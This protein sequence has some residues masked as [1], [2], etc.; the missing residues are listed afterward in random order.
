MNTTVNAQNNTEPERTAMYQA[1]DLIVVR[2]SFSPRG[3]IG[4]NSVETRK[5]IGG[6]SRRVVPY[7]E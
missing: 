1:F 6:R 7:G 2:E 3:E 4:A 5:E